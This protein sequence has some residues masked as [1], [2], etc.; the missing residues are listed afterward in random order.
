MVGVTI[1]VLE[2]PSQLLMGGLLGELDQLVAK[3]L[4]DWEL[5]PQVLTLIKLTIVFRGLLWQL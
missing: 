3:G 4:F 5:L 1:K 2:R